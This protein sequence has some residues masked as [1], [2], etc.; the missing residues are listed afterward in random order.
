MWTVLKE[1]LIGYWKC[2]Q[3]LLCNRER[4]LCHARYATR[5]T[6]PSLNPLLFC[7]LFPIPITPCLRPFFHFFC[8]D[9]IRG[10]MNHRSLDS[11][12]NFQGCE[13]LQFSGKKYP[14]FPIISKRHKT[15]SDNLMDAGICAQFELLGSHV[16]W[17]KISHPHLERLVTIRRLWLVSRR[18]H[19]SYKMTV[20]LT[21]FPGRERSLE[22]GCDV[23]T[24]Y[25]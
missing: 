24:A 15:N 9:S 21:S 6:F 25:R 20:F 17:F 4:A 10:V 16:Q 23:S 8:F 2:Y 3:D 12:C 22:R 13:N 18:S 5:P 14:T 7:L 19:S 1:V 11:S